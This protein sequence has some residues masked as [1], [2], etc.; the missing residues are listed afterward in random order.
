MREPYTNQSKSA[1]PFCNHRQLS[2]YSW[3]KEPLPFTTAQFPSRKLLP[4]VASGCRWRTKGILNTKLPPRR[5]RSRTSPCRQE[6]RPLWFHIEPAGKEVPIINSRFLPTQEF[7]SIVIT[8]ADFSPWP[9]DEVKASLQDESA[10]RKSLWD[11]NG[12]NAMSTY[13]GTSTF[14]TTVGSTRSSSMTART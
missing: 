5:G 8:S 12:T 7:I 6:G 11:T 10:L 2:S 14:N 9:T 13:G 4:A 1:I 3:V